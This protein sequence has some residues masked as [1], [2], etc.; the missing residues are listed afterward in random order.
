MQ[1]NRQKIGAFKKTV[2]AICT[3]AI[4]ILIVSAAYTYYLYSKINYQ[5]PQVV[6]NIN[7]SSLK[8]NSDEA[9]P[10]EPDSKSIKVSVES[11]NA[12]GDLSR[13]PPFIHSFTPIV[14]VKQIDPLITNVLILGLDGLDPKR[15]NRSDSMIMLSIDQRHRSLKLTSFMRD[16]YVKLP[17][18]SIGRKLNEAYVFGG[19]GNT[20]NT[21][22]YFFGLDIQKY[23]TL[24]FYNFQKVIDVVGDIEIDIAKREIPYIQGVTSPGLQ[25]LTGSQALQYARI[26]HADSDFFRV[27]RQR[28]VITAIY[29]KFRDS[30]LL[31]KNNI[32]NELLPLVTTNLRLN[33][34]IGLAFNSAENFKSN[35]AQYTVPK[36]GMY[37]VTT[38][39][40]YYINT[41]F[42]AQKADLHKFIYGK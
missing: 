13:L 4:L 21:I 39:L 5:A 12:K 40:G 27:Q 37:N 36:E 41:D 19:P 15:A 35:I 29:N 2:I 18:W 16:Q 14:K 33:E 25:K 1:K 28:N 30:D 20:I 26:R 6:D 9:V 34:I 22:N 3:F 24:D 7:D 32:L 42:A 17:Y 38:D 8:E 10:T 31:T 11:N 23:V